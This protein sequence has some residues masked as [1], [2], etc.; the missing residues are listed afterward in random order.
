M[1]LLNT[2]KVCPGH[3]D[4][5]F[6]QM[7]KDKKQVFS[8]A[9]GNTVAYADGGFSF[10][11]NGE[12]F[13][14]TVRTTGCD[15]LVHEGKCHTC[16]DYRPTLR[17]M[18]SRW[19]KKPSSQKTPKK[20]T[21]HRFMNT[22]QKKKKIEKLQ[23]RTSFLEREVAILKERISAT[24]MPVDAELNSELT[25]TMEENND[26]MLAQFPIGSFKRLFWEQQMQAARISDPRQMRWHPVMIKWCLNL[27]L[28]S[29]SSYHA[30]RTTGFVHLPSERTL[31]DYT[32][33]VKGR[34]GFQHDIDEDLKR[35]AD[36]KKLPDWK[37]HVLI[38]IDEMKIKESLVYD[39]HG[40]KII[41]FIDIGDI[42][43]QLGQLQS[44]CLGN[45]A[46]LVQS[47]ASHML[48]LMVRGIFTKLEYPY[49]HFPT[50]RLT[51]ASLFSIIWEGVERLEMLGFKVLAITADGAAINR[52]KI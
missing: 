6:Q 34:S 47:I 41:G 2:A 16:R 28:L 45:G 10:T 18:Y 25:R 7:V 1:Q 23:M 11:L 5:K 44:A 17:A 35:E 15:I 38:L 49:A 4:P 42:N 12:I 48:V 39:K 22:P 29:S 46:D 31:R 19:L 36:L 20:F 51:A 27:K 3:P 40:T 52:K 14:C 43:N 9:D 21:N 32:H 26:A 24:A 8:S 37:K 33:Y 30:L 50:H 13:D